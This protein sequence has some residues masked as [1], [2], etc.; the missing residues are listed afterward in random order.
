MKPIVARKQVRLSPWR[1]LRLSLNGLAYRLFRSLVTVSVLGLAV[2]FLAHVLAY[3][4]IAQSTRHAAVVELDR[5]HLLGEWVA[6]LS[7][8]D[9]D[10]VIL[11]EFASP[12]AS[13]RRAEYGAWSGAAPATLASAAA[14][15]RELV[16]V[17]RDVQALPPS[18]Q[19]VLTSLVDA[20]DPLTFAAQLADPVIGPRFRARLMELGGRLPLRDD[21]T[22]DRLVHRDAP[23]F[24]E[25]RQRIRRGQQL[26]IE[27]VREATGGVAPLHLL[28]DP[29]ADLH[30]V[31]TAAG[32]RLPR[33][34]L[35]PLREQALDAL[36]TEALDRILARPEVREGVRRRRDLPAAALNAAGILMWIDSDR[37][38]AALAA[39][40]GPFAEDGRFTPA[41]LRELS[42]ALQR[43]AGLE[44]AAGEPS[45]T[46]GG[47][48]RALPAATVWLIAISLF[49]CVVGVANA[50]L[51][52]ITERFAE[53][54]TMKCLGALN[55]SIIQVF[56]F[57]ALV[58]GGFG[59]LLGAAL[60]TGL[61]VARGVA[62][63]GSLAWHALP[64]AGLLAGAGAACACGVA[65]AAL[66]AAGPVWAAARLMP[67]EAMR[68]E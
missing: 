24:E 9:S 65:L 32:F 47:D 49:V 11:E 25:L 12:A 17:W 31:L 35:A 46:S 16:G 5:I 44:A 43:R 28:A 40:I 52:S 18:V 41:R 67:L 42:S 37:R 10:R 7:G 60:G 22:F 13:D 53:I 57:E 45:A 55:R 14:A 63:F 23:A 64:L 19:A 29:P 27:K 58:Q 62:T 1:C 48:R 39:A 68:I 21:A 61:A 4:L 30:D 6:R 33:H 15:G 34:L 50:M 66:A 26:A 59:S 8:P 3:G 20:D 2:A 54:A 36:D 51:M 38:A 56:L